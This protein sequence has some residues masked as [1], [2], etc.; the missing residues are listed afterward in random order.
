MDMTFKVHI[1]T[2]NNNILYYEKNVTLS[3]HLHCVRSWPTQLGL[4]N[5]HVF[6]TS[7]YEYLCHVAS[8]CCPWPLIALQCIS[9]GKVLLMMGNKSC[10]LSVNHGCYTSSPTVLQLKFM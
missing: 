2:Y 7:V 4:H 1:L 8:A 5:D 3:I 10:S 6:V 9:I